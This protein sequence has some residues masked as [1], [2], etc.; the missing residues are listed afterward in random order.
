MQKTD[1]EEITRVGAELD[2]EIS[3]LVAINSLA[4]GNKPG[5]IPGIIQYHLNNLQNPK[6]NISG[7]KFV[8]R[9]RESL[10]KSMSLIGTPRTL[11]A[12][13]A[14]FEGLDD[15]TKEQISLK[16]LRGEE[17]KNYDDMMTRGRSFFDKVYTKHSSKAFEK[18]YSNYPDLAN[19]VIGE[20]YG[21][22]MAETRLINEVETELCFIG[23]LVPMNVPIQLKSHAIGA[24]R[25]GARE[26]VVEAA[27]KIGKL[28]MAKFNDFIMTIEDDENVENL[29][30]L[31]VKQDIKKVEDNTQLEEKIPDKENKRNKKKSGKKVNREVAEGDM[32]TNFKVDLDFEGLEAV[33]HTIDFSLA[34]ASLAAKDGVIQAENN[35]GIE[36][37]QEKSLND[38]GDEHDESDESGESGES[39]KSDSESENES[40]ED[41]SGDSD[42]GDVVSDDESTEYSALRTKTK[43]KSNGS[44]SDS[45]IEI[46][47][48]EEE[49]KKQY[50]ADENDLD[51]KTKLSDELETFT[52]M[53]LSR[54]IMKGLSLLG[55][56]K[57]T[58]IQTKTI[59]IGLL[60]KDICGS[61]VTGS[62]KT[63]AF[64]VPVL[65]RLL[66][67]PNKVPLTRVLILAP[68]RELAMQCHNVATKISSFT[69]IRICLCVGGLSIKVQ[70]NELKERPDIVIATPGRLIDHVRNSPS[71][72]LDHIEI[73]IMDEADRMLEDGFKDEL[74]EIVQYCPKKRQ[75]MLF[76]ATMTDNINDLI[77]MSLNRPVR[78]MV[79]PPK[80]TS[81]KLIQESKMAAHQFKI[82]FGL[83]GLKAGELHGSLNQ[84]A[85]M[86]ALEHFRDGKV[87]F[88]MATDL[89]SRGLDI[90]G[91]QTVINYNM[92]QTFD[93]YLHRVGRTARAGRG[94]RAVTLV[95][96]SDRKM[97]KMA[98]KA[99]N[100]SGK[101]SV[102]QRVLD[103]EL[104]TKYKNKLDELNVQVEEILKMEKQES[105]I[106]KIEMEVNKAEN[107][108]K[109]D[110]EIHSRPRRTWFMTEKEKKESKKKI[111][112]D[113][114]KKISA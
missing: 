111:N 27:L 7:V 15:H 17:V 114:K 107:L 91:I 26:S 54:P 3:F 58:P 94:G 104:V 18:I 40:E 97:L 67:R 13:N 62:G 56:V 88:L 102:K 52:N 33:P 69:D 86:Q 6:D 113:Y 90:N 25:L 31:Y 66:F 21:K 4:S 106:D 24:S 108:I 61:A 20:F 43:K 63:A 16:P 9:A 75:T 95:G 48:E 55:F 30:E 105:S 101:S 50:F 79:D 51:L 93:L 39:D 73:L 68:T 98:I 77:R 89:A 12:I 65:E 2:H 1:F 59:P 37:N 103:A 80:Q 72:S 53:N 70:E 11:N 71:F 28:I 96:E 10:F 44:D 19:F 14:V 42:K 78:L 35:E 81:T 60:G 85:R 110:K 22:I 34:R 82:L 36:E 100:K 99:A 46:D 57:P 74:T 32:D 76:S 112:N 23:A 47:E 84:E 109:F 8:E 45:D 41:I 64:L 29:D 38:T 87:D 92:P 49:R 5:K 83:L